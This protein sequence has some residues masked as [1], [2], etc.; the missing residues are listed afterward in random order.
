[1]PL[2]DLFLE[3]ISVSAQINWINWIFNYMEKVAM[4]HGER[5]VDFND[6]NSAITPPTLQATTALI[7]SIR[8]KFYQNVGGTQSAVPYNAMKIQAVY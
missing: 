1:M 8:V 4:K 2:G 6:R 7:S 5:W 3:H